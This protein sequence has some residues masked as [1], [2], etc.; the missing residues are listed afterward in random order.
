MMKRFIVFAFLATLIFCVGCKKDS[1]KPEEDDGRDPDKEILLRDS[2]YFY[3]LLFSLW[4]EKLPQPKVG[5]DGKAD[6]KAF[7]GSFQTSEEVF[8]ALRKDAPDDRF[9]FVDRAGT[10]SEEIQQG[11]YKE[12]GITPI[13]ISVTDQ[14]NNT[15]TN[16]YVKVVQKGSPAEKAGLI[17]GMKILSING[18][19]KIDY[20]T[21]EKQDFKNFYKVMTGEG[22]LELVVQAAGE[23]GTKKITVSAAAYNID[24][25]L[26]KKIFTVNRKK[27]GYL[28]YTSFVNVFSNSKP[29]AY[30]NA[31]LDAF[32]EFET[33]N[34]DELV[35]DL[36]YNG[37]GSTS[38]A[39]FMANL[40]APVAAGKGKMYDYKVNKNLAEAGW[41][42]N[43]N[44][45]APFQSVNF[46]KT[47]S[48]NLPRVY[49]LGTT[50][51]ASASELVINVLKP[52][53][54]VELITTNGRGTYGKPVGFFGW[55]TV[56]GYADL[57]ITSFQMNNKDG[58]GDYFSGL[59]GQKKD[60]RDG[61]LTQ[62]G[63]E[64]ESLLAAALDHI[65]TG[66]YSARASAR[67]SKTG[68]DV[69]QTPQQ[70][71][72]KSYRNNMYKFSK[73]KMPSLPIKD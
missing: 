57:Y 44:P 22:A 73:D 66:S 48:L 26:I 43:S 49:F 38:S 64:S 33:A 45:E 17:R 35:V 18:D 34:I 3:S 13:Y 69:I 58:Y 51:T 11:V 31:M 6:L 42:D 20:D 41:N 55:P 46:N 23:T 19:S 14:N 16:L 39:E 67:R 56:N 8:A 72:M 53:M 29:N 25:I 36:R 61:F 15:E 21:D 71:E 2:T 40:I 28:F 54:T 70:P 12:T 27:V 5:T 9:S 52:Y 50:S 37:G 68:L 63:D 59:T 47:N 24:P 7:T 60:A 1:V 4:E 10:V 65:A 32:K 62:L 30:Y